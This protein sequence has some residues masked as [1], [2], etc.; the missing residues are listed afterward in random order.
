MTWWPDAP[1]RRR[2]RLALTALLLAAVPASALAQ[3]LEC[4]GTEGE[5]EVRSLEFQGNDAF[6]DRDLALPLGAVA[7]E[8]LRQRAR[9]QRGEEERCQP[10]TAAAPRRRIRPPLH[11]RAPRPP[12]ARR[13][14]IPVA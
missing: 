7:L 14:V 12:R 9:R 3:G 2:C 10:E 6:S 11:P 13:A 8:P 1:T 4:D 5:R